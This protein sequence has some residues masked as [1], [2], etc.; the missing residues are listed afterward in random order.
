MPARVLVVGG[1]VIGSAVGYWAAYQSG[2]G[3]PGIAAQL[4]PL[5]PLAGFGIGWLV[6]RRWERSGASPRGR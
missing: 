5:V 1:G 6:G 4:L 2:G 3:S